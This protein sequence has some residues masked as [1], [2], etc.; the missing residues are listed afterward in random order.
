MLLLRGKK[1][2]SRVWSAA[3]TDKGKS[4]RPVWKEERSV[5][6]CDVYATQGKESHDYWTL[7]IFCPTDKTAIFWKWSNVGFTLMPLNIW[8]IY[9]PL[10]WFHAHQATCWLWW[11]SSAGQAT[12]SEW[13]ILQTSS[14]FC[15]HTVISHDELIKLLLFMTWLFMLLHFRNRMMSWS[16]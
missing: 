9:L 7:C 10:L 12:E 6:G 11:V 8:F 4:Q 3:C 13:L 15:L 1:Q 2:S 14:I 5:D 16:R